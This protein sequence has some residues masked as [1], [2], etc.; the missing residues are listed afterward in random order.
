MFVK[1]RGEQVQDGALLNRHIA[2]NAAIHESKLDIDWAAHGTEI[3]E[4]K[5]VVDWV[6][7]NDL[8]V[9]GT[10]VDLTTV[11]PPETPISDGTTKGVIVADETGGVTNRVII[12]GMDGNPILDENEDEVYGRLVFVPAEGEAPAKFVLKFFSGDEVPFEMPADTL[13]DF[14]YMERF[15]LATVSELFAANEKFVDGVADV[16]STLNI[17]Q[18]AQDLYG[19]EYSLDRDGDA[20]LEKPLV[21]QIADEVARATAEEDRIEAK[22]DQE[23]ADRA[24]ADAAI[25]SDLA[26]TEAGKGA[27]LIGVEDAAGHFMATTVEGALAELHD[28]A[29]GAIGNNDALKVDLADTTD[30]AK[31]ANL[32]GVYDADNK[33][34]AETVNGA[35]LELADKVAAEKERAENAEAA[36]D[37]RVDALETEVTAAR[38]AVESLD[39]RLDVVLNEDGTLKVGSQI[40][41]HHRYVEQ[42]EDEKTVITLPTDKPRPV[43]DC[44]ATEVYVNGILQ[45]PGIHYTEVADE[46]DPSVVA[47]IDF[48]P[49][50]LVGTDVVIVK[51]IANNA[52]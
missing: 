38:G 31:G 47:K 29:T 44:E 43:L 24:A 52:E 1:I 3:L 35:L 39:A 34:E 41:T 33:L 45:A 15:S 11:L 21:E 30:P 12:R 2:A 10:E 8:L 36:L 9:A 7:V 37:G 28:L 13:I 27:A 18:L 32:V 19:A 50:V 5:K 51:W 42:V 6:Q 22:L 49:E 48:A 14:Q 40:H 16:T 4:A 23:I 20:N 26:S 46:E 25:L 17:K